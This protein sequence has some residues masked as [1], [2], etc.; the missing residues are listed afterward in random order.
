MAGRSSSL[1]LLMS[2]FAGAVHKYGYPLWAGS[3]SPAGSFRPPSS[4]AFYDRFHA[5]PKDLF[6]RG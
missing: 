2:P 3:N 1:Q 5:T 6:L 4:R